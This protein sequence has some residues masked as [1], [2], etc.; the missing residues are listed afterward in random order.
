MTVSDPFYSQLSLLLPF[1][2]ADGSRTFTDESPFAH[3]P[4]TSGSPVIS[5]THSKAGNALYLN[6]SS[7]LS[8]ATSVAFALG[9]Q[10]FAIGVWI[11]AETQTGSYPCLLERSGS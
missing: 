6:G 2:A 3:T 11:W 1:D 10:D 5:A 9:A 7:N 4:T 8:Y